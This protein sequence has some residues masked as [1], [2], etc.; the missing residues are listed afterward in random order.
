MSRL[1]VVTWLLLFFNGVASVANRPDPSTQQAPA[2][3]GSRREVFFDR[4][5]IAR[6]D[7]TS[8]VLHN[9]HDEGEVLRLD[10]PWEGPFSGYSTVIKDERLFRLYYRGKRSPGSDGEGEVTCYA[11]STDGVHWIKPKLGLFLV[12]GTRDNNVIL[13]EPH[14]SHNFS[15]FLD[16]RPGV[17]PNER[18]KALGG[19]IHKNPGGG[20]MAYASADGVRWRKL[21]DRPVLT[22]GAFDSQNLAFW[23]EVDQSYVSYFRTF[24]KGVSTAFEWK[25]EGF[26]SFSRS[27]SRDFLHWEDP[28]P[29]KFVP[30]QEYHLYTSQVQPYFRAPHLLIATAAR[31]MPSREGISPQ[32]AQRLQVASTYF[33]TARDVSDS[34]FLTSHDG[35]TFLQTFRE[36]LIRPG[37]RL[38]EWVSRSGYPALN[39]VQ[40][41]PEEMSLYLNQDYAQ[42]T[43]HLRRYSLRLDGFAS[44]NAGY[45]GG[46]F[47]TRPLIF[48]GRRLFLNCATSAAG[49]IRV[50]IQEATGKPVPGFSVTDAL[51]ILG[52][53]CAV[54]VGWHGNPDLGALAGRTVRL[55]FVMKDADVFGLQFAP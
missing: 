13:A 53:G 48:S 54:E 35:K 42:P 28:E 2:M 3:I 8:L 22:K 52:N 32:E 4:H 12:A 5:L 7:G 10:Q 45:E 1:V 40:T 39:V 51:E 19:V 17:P 46:E 33:K 9:P 21:G 36:A 25:L 38:N 24:T 43:A 30:P 47:V 41:G 34:V 16:T 49:G 37:L 11:E 20:L 50:E 14:V 55:R 6:M 29:L 44:V 26:R 18:Y 31:F 23:S 27:R 15:P